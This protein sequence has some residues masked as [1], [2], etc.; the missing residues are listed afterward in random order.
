MSEDRPPYAATNIIALNSRRYDPHVSG[1]ALCLVCG[2][3]WIAVAP[4]GTTDL[5]CPRCGTLRGAW[6]Y[7]FSS[8]ESYGVFTCGNAG[9]G[10]QHMMIRKHPTGGYWVSCC[11]CGTNHSMDT[12]FPPLTSGGA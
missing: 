5:L 7:P 6:R 10:C 3:E 9:C 2:T 1:H 11:R 4:L 12:V 8:G